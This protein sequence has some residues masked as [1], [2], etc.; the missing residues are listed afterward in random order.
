MKKAGTVNIIFCGTGGQGVLKASEICAWAALLEGCHVKK[1]EV[2]GMSQRG[3]SV[4]SHLRFGKKVYSPLV[5]RGCADFLVPLHKEEAPALKDFLSPSGRDYS[6]ELAAAD[7]PA[8]EK[9]YLNSFMCGRLA[10][11]LSLKKGSWLKA[12]DI[13]F[14]KERAT[15][16]K[17]VFLAGYEGTT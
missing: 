6:G 8:R 3:G 15:E 5:P 10:A 1:S 11:D 7:L 13:V 2:H 12:I 4:E 17:R 16:N 14:G 9:R